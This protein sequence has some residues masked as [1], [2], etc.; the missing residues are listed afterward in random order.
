MNIKPQKGM[1]E[2]LPEA[3]AQRD[4]LM[5]LI[6]GTYTNCGFT[7]IYTPAVE[8]AEN[9]DKSDGGDNLN[10]IFKILKRGEKLEAALAQTPVDE[11]ELCDLGLR[12]DLTLPLSRYYANN[13]NSLPNPFKCIQIDKVY[14]AERPQRGRLREFVQCDID[15]LGSDSICC[16]IELISVTA[17]A[18][19]KIGIGEFSVRVNDRRILRDSLK[20]MGFPEDALD[21]VSVTF[22]K[23]DKIGA[24]GV[25]DELR[26]KGNITLDDMER[27]CSD[28]AKD[29]IAQLRTIIETADKLS[30]D[31]SVVYDPSLVRGQGYYTGTVFEVASK[32]FGGTVAG[33][34]RYDG[35]IGRFTGENIPAVG[36][37][38][39]FE[40]IFSIVTEN[41][42]QLSG[43]RPRTA[44]LYKAEDIL[45]AIQRSSELEGESDV[46]LVLVPNPKKSDKIYTRTKNA[47]FDEIIKLNM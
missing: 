46:T 7:R 10:L 3:A 26:E 13:R 2:Y 35:L 5:S 14:R 18:L 8:S 38:I 29:I 15:I 45:A 25:S 39:G 1:Q 32:Q 47:G 17:K 22:D 27:Y 31:Y 23:L 28:G 16:E 19:G 24:D 12:Y 4:R 42:I 9:L 44:I 43:S 33:G 40:R 21:T 36:F 6:L 30:P 11:K 41:N 37:S 34:G 20:T